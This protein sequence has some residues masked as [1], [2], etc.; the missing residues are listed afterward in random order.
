MATVYEHPVST[1]QNDVKQPTS[2]DMST[3][4]ASAERKNGSALDEDI[5]RA[6]TNDF[7][8]GLMTIANGL[9]AVLNNKR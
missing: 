6:T 5:K 9:F 7:I 8:N 1:E 2:S 3:H 4:F